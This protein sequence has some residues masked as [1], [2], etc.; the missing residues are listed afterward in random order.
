MK[1]LTFKSNEEWMFA[2]LGKVTGSEVKKTVTLAG[3]ETKSGVYRRVY[4][5]LAGSVAIYDEDDEN[6][7]NRGH[8]LEPEALERFRKETGKKT[9]QK[10]VL[11]VSEEDERMAVSPDDTIGK[12]HTEAVEV[13]CLSGAKHIE[14]IYTRK[15]PKN[16]GGYEEQRDQYFIVNPGLKKLYYVFYNPTLPESMQY[17]CIVFT[18][19]ELTEQIAKTHAA[20]LQSTAKVREIVNALS[21]YS[22][23]ELA[24]AEK[25]REELLTTQQEDV[26]KVSKSVDKKLALKELADGIKAR[27]Y[28]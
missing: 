11:W 5:S 4:E 18:R 15:I 17:F 26:E 2:R 8:R 14:A 24:Q 12:N 28:D 27:K 19:K 9:N 13:K 1:I 3:S 25:V 7:M 23:K 16:T 22:P 10:L 20:E 6:A 21:M